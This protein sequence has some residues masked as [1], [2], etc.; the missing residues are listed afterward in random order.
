MV[1]LDNN[2]TTAVSPAAATAMQACLE[3]QVANP[4][5]RQISADNAIRNLL[6]VSGGK[7]IYTSGGTENAAIAFASALYAATGDVVCSLLDHI[8]VLNQHSAVANRLKTAVKIL[9]VTADGQ[10]NA[11]LFNRY[12]SGSTALV[13]LT[14]V[15]SE[16]GIV[17]KDI[18]DMAAAA[19]HK[20]NALL[21]MDACQGVGR[22]DLTECHRHADMIGISAHKFHGPRGVGALWVRPGVEAYPAWG[23]GFQ[24]GGLRSGTDNTL[25]ICGMQAALVDVLHDC[26]K[27]V[28]HMEQLRRL[29]DLRMLQTPGV[30]VNFGNCMR[31]CN[32]SSY[33]VKGV[34]TK[35]LR[36][37]LRKRGI[38]VSDTTSGLVD[39][40]AISPLM[41]FLHSEE[42]GY[43]N[44]R[45]SL[46]ANTTLEE[47]E[48]ATAMISQA[49]KT[50]RRLFPKPFPGGR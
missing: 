33:L 1:Y 38:V 26:D 41:T 6:G 44:V 12:V 16:T 10:P 37:L 28:L 47:V 5:H 24:Q 23:G 14:L 50:L 9:P 19:R 32:T 3:Q 11:E 27:K 8:S 2:A 40:S 13:T 39:S 46:S 17:G 4:L 21:Y 31:V 30:T 34:D 49:I 15:N 45:L 42:D 43:S 22:L 48:E 25:G 7:L 18:P 29:M 36:L 35:V 20:S